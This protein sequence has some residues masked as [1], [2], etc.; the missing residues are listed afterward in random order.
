MIIGICG[1]SGSGK[2]TLLKRLSKY[3]S[4]LNPVIF[5]M[6]NY[7]R[8]LNQQK[9]DANGKINFD[10]PT[11]LD[12]DLLA[13][14][15][16]NLV[17]GNPIEVKEYY[18]NAPPDKNV[19]ITLYPSDLIIVEGLFLFYFKKVKELL[20]YSIF[21]DVHPSTQLD[22]RLYRDQE[23]RGY[24]REAILYQWDNHVLPCYDQYLVP[25]KKEANFIFRND[26]HADDDFEKLI[27]AL[28]QRMTNLELINKN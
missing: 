18:F 3:Y 4:D 19:L 12:E 20:N 24:S 9:V 14:D 15:L 5:S 25:Y 2:T 11:A 28:D 27:E 16:Q 23:T 8:P 6:D 22:R 13:D 21:I 1:G 26:T 17:N 10:L 7:Y